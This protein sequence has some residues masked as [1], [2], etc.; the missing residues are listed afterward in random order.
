[1]LYVS[2]MIRWRWRWRWRKSSS[3]LRSYWLPVHFNSILVVFL[4]GCE[5]HVPIGTTT[6][7]MPYITRRRYHTGTVF[8]TAENLKIKIMSIL[9][10]KN[11]NLWFKITLVLIMLRLMRL[12]FRFK[13]QYINGFQKLL[14]NATHVIMKSTAGGICI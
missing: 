4:K 9:Y 3:V 5:T 13:D 8:F 12:N 6:F 14:L 10:Y 2:S 7:L 11:S 1:M